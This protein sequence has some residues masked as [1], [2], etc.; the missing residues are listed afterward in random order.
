MKKEMKRV[1]PINQSRKDTDSKKK[2][3]ADSSFFSCLQRFFGHFDILQI[4]PLV[5]LLSIG[6]LFIYGAGH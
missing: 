2:D 3:D 5:S 4:I 6:C 1:N